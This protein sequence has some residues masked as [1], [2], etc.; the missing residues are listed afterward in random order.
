MT[1]PRI[2][3]CY[4][5]PCTDICIA[6]PREHNHNT[7]ASKEEDQ[8]CLDS[9]FGTWSPN[10]SRHPRMQK[11]GQEINWIRKLFFVLGRWHYQYILLFLHCGKRKSSLI[12]TY[13]QN[14]QNT[15]GVS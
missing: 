14:M 8:K 3:T 6:T 4:H 7:R 2:S 5:L 15:S 13:K 1:L 12:A 10:H 11:P 9:I